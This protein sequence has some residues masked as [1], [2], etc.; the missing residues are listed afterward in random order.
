MDTGLLDN[1]KAEIKADRRS[2]PT[3][4]RAKDSGG[5]RVCPR[6]ADSASGKGCANVEKVC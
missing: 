6:L 5:A 1:R 2:G 4:Q 3:P